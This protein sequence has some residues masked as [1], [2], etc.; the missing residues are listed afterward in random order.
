MSGLRVKQIKARLLSMFEGH[1]SLQ[2]ISAKDKERETKIV[3]RCL[4]AFGIFL[5]TGCTEADAAA[6]VWDGSDDNG[7]DAVFFDPSESKVIVVQS[8]WISSGSGEPQAKD[9]GAFADG[10]RDLVEQ[11][12]SN[13]GD[14]LQSK[15]SEIGQAILVPGV[16]VH[17]VLISTGSSE[18]NFHGNAKIQRVLRE[19]NG[20][21]E[22]NLVATSQVIGI[23]E[24]FKGLA[25]NTDADN[26]V[27]D[28]NIFDWSSVASPYVA[29]FGLVDGLQ[30]K[31]WWSKYGKRLVAKNIRHA[32]GATDV[33]NQ[34]RN[35]AITNPESFWYFNNG[36][37]IIANEALKAPKGVA[38][39]ASGIFQFKGASIVN[40]AQTVSTLG[41]VENEE[42]LGKVRVPFRVVILKN[43][44]SGFGSEVTRTNNL[45]NRIEARD[46]VAQDPE[47][48]RIQMEMAIEGIEYQFLR[49]DDFVASANSCELIEITTA[50]ACASGD[51]NLAVQVKTGIGRF[52]NDLKKPPYKA[53]FN[54]SLSGAKA[55]NATLTQRAI[56]IWI[57][58]KKKDIAKK[59]GFSWGV[60]IHGNRILSSAIFRNLGQNFIDQPIDEFRKA[61]QKSNF[62]QYCEKTY[63]M[64]VHELEENY[65]GKFLAVLFKNPAMSK[66]VFHRSTEN[67]KI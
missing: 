16:T 34:I 7:V 10:V 30:L 24:V 12:Y 43:A 67:F 54:P 57:D 17:I 58:N 37:T 3:T 15:L 9:I 35:T 23:D 60:L 4:A 11:D 1:L 52:F 20:H 47:Q 28:A 8:K 48:G 64:M 14:R 29:Y 46:F 41:R 36:I 56:D 5:T 61:L 22:Q 6:A 21:D 38:A 31:E 13:F 19:L 49:S 2:D 39:R 27:I 53:I 40:G 44:P 50:L 33:N 63:E 18:I 62:D 51:P 65:N 32:L 25:T 66:D 59:S 55:F 42:S 26:I 45:Q